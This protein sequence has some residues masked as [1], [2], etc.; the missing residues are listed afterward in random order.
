MATLRSGAGVPV[1][2][3]A[4]GNPGGPGHQWV[5]ARYIDPAPLGFKISRIRERAGAGLYSLSGWRQQVLGADYVQQL[6]ASGSKELVKA[7]LEGD[8]S[9][10]EGAFFD[11]WES[12]KHVIR[13]LKSRLTGFALA[14]QTGDQLDLFRSD[15]G[16]WWGTM[17]SETLA[18]GGTECE[19]PNA[20]AVLET[21]CFTHTPGACR[22]PAGRDVRYREWYGR[23]GPNEGLKLTAEQVADGILKREQGDKI[24]MAC[25][26]PP[27]LQS[28]AGL[29]LP[30]AW[31][32]R[33]LC[34]HG[35]TTS[36]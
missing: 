16:P 3:R 33:A 14:V 2:F 27:P 8:W 26:T 6:K 25:W 29:P 32:P 24:P 34:S 7:W 19:Q 20:D 31:P 18:G 15:G 12:S 30:S 17:T 9:V 1:G 13:L 10:I 5:K 36:A 21:R 23:N 4:T 22:Y 35:P 11:C 28:M